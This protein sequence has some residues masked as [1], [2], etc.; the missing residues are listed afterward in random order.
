MCLS[1]RCLCCHKSPVS[2][3]VVSQK[4]K[5]FKK[6]LR[7]LIYVSKNHLRQKNSKNRNNKKWFLD[8]SV[9]TEFFMRP[10]FLKVLS[11]CISRVSSHKSELFSEGYLKT[12]LSSHKAPYSEIPRKL[13][14]INKPRMI[15]L[16]IYWDSVSLNLSELTCE[17]FEVQLLGHRPKHN[18]A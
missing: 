16:F 4:P 2:Y 14:I 18:F 15:F 1:L 10:S 11:F 5:C 9:K 13:L 6:F 17:L 3:R 12:Y 7:K 8:T